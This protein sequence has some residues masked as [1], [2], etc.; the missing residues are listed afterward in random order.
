[1][2]RYVEALL[3]PEEQVLLTAAWPASPT[4]DEVRRAA[5]ALWDWTRHVWREAERVLGRPLAIDLD[6]AGCWRRSIRSMPGN[7]TLD[8]PA[9]GR[10]TWLCPASSEQ[11]SPPFSRAH[12]S[13]ALEPGT[14][15]RPR[16]QQFSPRKARDPCG[17][18]RWEAPVC[19][20]RAEI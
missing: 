7:E 17:M 11:P 20:P 13:L 5:R 2:F 10:S 14:E 8:R 3:S 15:H 1:G 4:R 12:R 16:R 18:T 9:R 6:E 19:A